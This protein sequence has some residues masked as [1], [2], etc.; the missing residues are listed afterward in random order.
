MAEVSYTGAD[1]Q[2]LEGL[3]PVRKRPG[4]Y[5]GGTGKAGLHHLVWEI[6]D[7]AV[8]E[9]TNG[10]ASL[11]EV[12]LHKDGKTVS[13]TDNGRGIPVDKHPVKKIPTL[14]VILTT[15][16]AGGKFDG[17]ELR[18]LGRPPRRRLVGRQR[19]LGVA[20]GP[21]QARRQALRA[22]L[23]QR[24]PHDEAQDGQDGRPRH[25]HDHHVHARRGHLRPHRL[26]RRHDQGEPGGQDVP[27]R[28][29]PDRV[30]ERGYGRARRVPPRGR[31]RGVP[32]PPRAGREHAAS[33]SGSVRGAPGGA[34]RRPALRDLLR[35][36]R[37]AEGENR[38]LRQRHP[39]ARRRHARAGPQ[40][41]DHESDPQL[42]RDARPRPAQARHH[43]RRHPRGHG[44]RPQPLPR[45][46]AVPG[47]DEGEAEQPR[48][49]LR[50]QRRLP[51]RVRAVP[52]RA[53]VHRRGDHRARDPVGQGAAG[54]PRGGAERAPQERRQPPPQP[55]GQA[56]RLLLDRPDARASCS[57]SRATPPAAAPSRAATARRRRSS[58]SAARSSTPSRPR[59]PR[60]PPTRN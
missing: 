25:G 32:R 53:P 7:N 59:A 54:E 44:R 51:D 16:H 27:Q 19:A 28:R 47:P 14:E 15:L 58:R 31:H 8:D 35:L 3:E 50:R 24:R 48:G 12:V 57:S 20:R 6:V 18:H 60:W 29:A 36:D 39:D 45:R 33:P 52:Q 42:H 5:I 40:G 41:R 34:R 9:A 10:Y 46:P 49:A 11:I 37:G 21:G 13:V 22:A 4:M 30:Q 26:R 38:L 43:G 2:V 56:R 23:R 17:Y 55:A 1:I